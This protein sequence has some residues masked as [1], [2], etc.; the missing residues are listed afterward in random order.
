MHTP[1]T[2][3][4][5]TEYVLCILHVCVLCLVTSTPGRP[6]S[7]SKEVTLTQ[8]TPFQWGYRTQY[9]RLQTKKVTQVKLHCCGVG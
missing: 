2:C 3:V 4:G 5:Y 7:P 8:R 9:T 1:L 6:S